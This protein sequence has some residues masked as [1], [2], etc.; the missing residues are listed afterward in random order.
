M[1][2]L[3]EK[4]YVLDHQRRFTLVR[5][6]RGEEGWIADRYLVEA[7]IFDQFEKLA[8]ENSK[9]PIQAHGTTRAALNLHVTP[10]R[11]TEHLFQLKEG[12]KVQILKRATAEKPGSSQP[13]PSPVRKASTTSK[14]D[15]APLQ[16]ALEDWSL[17]RSADGQTLDSWMSKSH[18]TLRNMRKASVS[19][20]AL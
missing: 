15:D 5:T 14:Q 8:A 12:E 10:G 3:G 7:T 13:R 4:V 18:S 17:I 2:K 1:V 19:C 6:E 16:P 9:T 11:D 20:R